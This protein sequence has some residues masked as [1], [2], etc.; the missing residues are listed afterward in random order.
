MPVVY[1]VGLNVVPLLWLLQEFFDL[2]PILMGEVP[3]YDGPKTPDGRV[4]TRTRS[5]PSQSW[6][7]SRFQGVNVTIS[8]K[9]IVFYKLIDYILHG[10]EDIK[11]IPW[12]A[13]RSS[14]RKVPD[15]IHRGWSEHD[16]TNQ[17]L[18]EKEAELQP[19]LVNNVCQHNNNNNNR[20][21][22]ASSDDTGHFSPNRVLASTPVWNVWTFFNHAASV[23]WMSK[24]VKA[25]MIRLGDDRGCSC[26]TAELTR[27]ECLAL[28]V[29]FL[30]MSVFVFWVVL[31][32]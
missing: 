17:S 7:V 8:L 6:R 15:W 25:E 24:Q 14:C 12:V 13:V 10:K 11:V 30:H 29:V 28:I 32:L 23:W 22:L 21:C 27:T 26:A 16:R 2:W 18:R 31:L 20:A 19:G 3:P 4:R 9:E 1:P 5:S